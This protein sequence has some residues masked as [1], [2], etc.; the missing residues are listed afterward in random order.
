MIT[1]LW[2]TAGVLYGL[3]GIAFLLERAL[4]NG[5]LDWLVV[6]TDFGANMEEETDN[7]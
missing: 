3:A 2:I 5:K 6:F 4:N 1:G 7:G